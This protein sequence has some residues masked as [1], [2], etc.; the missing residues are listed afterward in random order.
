MLIHPMPDPI[1]FTIGPLAVHWYG[2]MYLLAFAQFIALGRL[3]IRQP[4]IAAVGW[5]KEDLDDMLFY[6]VLGVIIG[7]RSV[8]SCFT[9]PAITSRIRSKFSRSGKAACHS[10]AASSAC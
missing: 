5:K 6:G 4:H 8:K 7:G 10:M 3:R 9:I 1:A 2:M